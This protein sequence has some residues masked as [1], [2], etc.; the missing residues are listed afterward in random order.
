VPPWAA[1][2]AGLPTV[3][4]ESRVND[5]LGIA[6]V[7]RFAVVM[8]AIYYLVQLISVQINASAWRDVGHQLRVAWDAAQAGRRVPQY[9]TQ[10]LADPFTLVV[11]VATLAAVVAACIW[12][13]RAATAA[14]ALGFPSRRSP[15][16][17][18]G[19]WFV[20]IVNLWIPYGAIRDCL[21]AGDPQR[22]HVLRWWIAWVIG[23]A[24]SF[25]AS[26][27]ALF[28][29][30]VALAVSVPAAIALLAVMAWAPGVVVSIAVAHRRAISVRSQDSDALPR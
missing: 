5:E 10:N 26:L 4:A 24:L 3:N 16:W 6:R 11:G 30:G 23:F 21:P 8:P 2:A 15:G 18:V 25:G 14:R 27:C 29:T 20:P 12:Q 28:S 13:H 1:A 9:H 19:A 7:A 17:G 22:A